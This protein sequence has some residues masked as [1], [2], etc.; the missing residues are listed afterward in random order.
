MLRFDDILLN[1][2]IFSCPPDI[3]R[4]QYLY[5]ESQRKGG[6]FVLGPFHSHKTYTTFVMGE[7]NRLSF[8]HPE[9]IAEYK[10]AII[11]M[12]LLNLDPLYQ[13]IAPL[14]P[15]EGRPALMQMEIFRSFILMCHLHI[16]LNNWVQKL[17]NNPVLRT[18]AGFTLENMPQ[19]TSYYDFID[20]IVPLEDK[21][22]VK[23]FKSKPKKKLKKGE[24]LPPRN[25]NIVNQLVR[26]VLLDEKLFRK[27]L[28]RRPER[29][30]QRIFARVAVDSS[31]NMGLIPESV[32][33]SG[34][35]TCIETGASHYG[36][37][38]CK[39]KANGIYRCDCDRKFSDPSA[40]WGWDSH[41]ERF[42]YGH[43][44]YFISTHNKDLRVDLPVYLRLVQAS[45]HDSVSAI[46]ALTEFRELNP[47]LTIDTFISDSASD[48]YA[49]YDLLNHWDVNAVI[50]LNKKNTGNNKLPLPLHIN[51]DGVPICP[52]GFKM[53]H[54]GFTKDRCR[55]KWRCPRSFTR[56]GLDRPACEGC[57]TSTYGRVFYTKPA[58]DLRLF[59]RIP[60]GSDAWNAKMRERTA[61]ERVNTRILNDYKLSQLR[62]RG[63]KRI[64]FM[65]VLAGINTHLDAQI[66]FLFPSGELDLSLFLPH[67]DA[68]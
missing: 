46:F 3:C 63:K 48:N 15:P 57:S 10:G 11:K 16:P 9:L 33:V 45:R 4:V 61:A 6:F 54:N 41:E 39:C 64:F 32:S 31:I 50:A 55:I 18:I 49:T 43:T 40:N 13:I 26:R 5:A 67:F 62:V 65:T 59:T 47:N 42:F 1:H 68:A 53:I 37:W 66:K 23:P 35:G 8:T 29:F 21:P 17:T 44:G 52:S 28:S 25:T 14:Y 12:L 22:V 20:R 56:D 38:I 2:L 51:D 30:L 19:T 34:D 60:R 24:K 7:L 27:R 58:W 36:K